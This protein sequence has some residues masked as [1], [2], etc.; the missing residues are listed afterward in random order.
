[1]TNPPFFVL[2]AILFSLSLTAC[3][4]KDAPKTP[5]TVASATE[6]APAD[7]KSAE[8]APAP[9]ADGQQAT[10]DGTKKAGNPEADCN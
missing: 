4:D 5:T 6:P 9:A 8:A 10:A 3:G 2:L 7:A 1:M